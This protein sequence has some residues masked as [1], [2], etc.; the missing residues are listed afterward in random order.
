MSN[1]F[2]PTFRPQPATIAGDDENARDFS[3]W[4]RETTAYDTNQVKLEKD[5]KTARGRLH[6]SLGHIPTLKSTHIQKL[7]VDP[8]TNIEYTDQKLLSMEWGLIKT[9]YMPT[10]SDYYELFKLRMQRS[11]DK[12]SMLEHITEFAACCAYI[13]QMVEIAGPLPN[14]YKED[15]NN[16]L[17]MV[18]A[19]EFM[20]REYEIREID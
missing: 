16:A 4:Q 17:N 19:T 10:I 5:A 9:T 13:L 6:T 1:N 11:S 7:V 3:N 15:P 14:L 2:I 12:N 8:D 20:Q 18:P